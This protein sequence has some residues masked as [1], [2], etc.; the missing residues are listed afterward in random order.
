MSDLLSQWV[1]SMLASFAHSLSWGTIIALAASAVLLLSLS[2]KA[3]KVMTQPRG[4]AVSAAI[5]VAG[6][7]YAW[8]TWPVASASPSQS[9]ASPAAT[10]LRSADQYA[11]RETAAGTVAA[12][13]VAKKPA[14][15]ATIPIQP[16]LWTGEPPLIVQIPLAGAIPRLP[17]VAVIKPVPNNHPVQHKPPPASSSHVNR[18]AAPVRPGGQYRPMPI[19][20][21][22]G[23]LSHPPG[24]YLT[25]AQRQRQIWNWQ[26]H[27]AEQVLNGMMQQMG[28]PGI[29][30][31]PGMGIHPMGGT[32][33]MGGHRPG[34]H[35]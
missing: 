1:W 14:V 24:P 28:G 2:A 8:W 33:H 16:L 15:M 12:R 19:R 26:N 31:G 5:M 13:A 6:A 25:P 18:P 22:T 32:H 9:Q 7:V 10:L 17:P 20:P 11:K 23:G 21:L 4:L 34:M 30:H 29:G 35:R 3:V 27:Q